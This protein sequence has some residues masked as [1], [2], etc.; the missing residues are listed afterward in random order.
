MADTVRCNLYLPAE[1]VSSADRMAI[2][3]G[4]T[5]KAVMVRALGVLQAIHDGAKEG[6]YTGQTRRREDLSVLL[7]GPL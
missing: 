5:R 3:G 6:Y 2:E 1:V 7:V 4:L